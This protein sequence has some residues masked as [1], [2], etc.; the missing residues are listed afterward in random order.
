MIEPDKSPPP[1]RRIR[2]VGVIVQLEV[3]ADDGTTLH[4]VEVQPFRVAATDWPTW[5][6]DDALV[7][8]QEQVD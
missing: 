4:P 3:V 6:I 1:R 7:D 5:S 2:L 8:L